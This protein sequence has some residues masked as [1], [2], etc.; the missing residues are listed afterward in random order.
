MLKLRE[1]NINAF[2]FIPYQLLRW[3]PNGT[4]VTHCRFVYTLCV[5]AFLLS[6][7]EA[8]RGVFAKFIWSIYTILH[9]KS[10]ITI[11]FV[12]DL[13]AAL[14]PSGKNVGGPANWRHNRIGFLIL[15]CETHWRHHL[16]ISGPIHCDLL[17]VRTRRFVITSREP[18]QSCND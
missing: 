15:L 17:F 11:P 9:G 5:F 13:F 16:I 8:L 12:S 6:V 7:N 2:V 3:N 1:T 10:R 18:I 4:H 14:F